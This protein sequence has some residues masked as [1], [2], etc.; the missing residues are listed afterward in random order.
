M[1][2]SITLLLF[3]MLLFVGF[4]YAQTSTFTISLDVAQ[5]NNGAGSGGT[6]SGSGTAT[7]DHGT[8]QLSVTGSFSG[9]TGN[10]TA[11]HVHQAPAGSGGGVTFGLTLTPSGTTAGDFNGSG[12]LDAGE[13]TALLANGMYVNVHTTFA[14]GG[15]IRGQIL[16]Q[17]TT[18]VEMSFFNA[19]NE[20]GIA[21]LQ[22]ATLSELNNAYFEIQHSLNGKDFSTIDIME[23]NGTTFETSYYDYTHETPAN[24]VNYYRLRQVDFDEKYEFSDVVSVAI[25]KSELALYPNPASSQITV[26][27]FNGILNIY[28]AMGRMVKTIGNTQNQ[29]ISIQDLPNGLY[30]VVD[31]Q[32]RST[33]FLKQ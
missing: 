31:E 30:M 16:L 24:G 22:W 18:P 2:K 10:T 13:E 5:A 7:Y 4:T 14:G 15:E 17:N 33:K 9:L 23:G 20:N 11:C 3:I 32:G 21:K 26:N 25:E 1:K 6:G 12:T 29:T 27:N 19:A 28:D 8:M